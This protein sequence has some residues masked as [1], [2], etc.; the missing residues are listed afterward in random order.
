MEIIIG[1]TSGFCHGVK[2]AVDK[3]TQ[4]VEQSNEQVYCLG[5]LVHNKQ[6]TNSLQE[7][8][9][10][11][12]EN[13]EEAK[14]KTI[15]RAHGVT[16][17]IY[18]KAQELKIELKDLTC[19]KVLKIH[20]LAEEYSKKAY[21]IFLVGM[22]NHPETIGTYSFCGKNSS[23]IESVVDL[24]HVV[25]KMQQTN[26]KKALLITQ[27]T[28]NL[29]KFEE[30]SER[31]KEMLENNVELKVINTICASTEL[32]Q[33]E[34]EELSQK[35]DLMLIIGGRNSS[36]TNKLYEIA[37]KNCKNVIFAETKEDID[38]NQIKQ[39]EKIGVMAGASTPRQSI[40]SIV[41]FIKQEGKSKCVEK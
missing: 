39:F 26:I 6:V 19:P 7:K 15:I 36:N 27:T 1:K 20:E 41:E 2:N 3:A 28:F 12:I 9:L 14:G 35:V 40:D 4:E 11:F 38:I 37:S 5:E 32:R 21:Y 18:R 22:S 34:T 17:E 33:K 29:R 10:T 25:T 30:I 31:L 8:G 13:I 16:K 23:I 24:E